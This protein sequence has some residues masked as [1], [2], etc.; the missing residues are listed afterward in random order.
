ML[1][2]KDV[3]SYFVNVSKIKDQ[4]EGIGEIIYDFELI[5]FLLNGLPPPLNG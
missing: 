4:I 1:K 5:T 3:D 2:D